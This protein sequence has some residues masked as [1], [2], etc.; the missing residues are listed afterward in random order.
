M[1]WPASHRRD[2]CRSFHMGR[3]RNEVNVRSGQYPFGKPSCGQ[4]R[5]RN[6][7]GRVSSCFDDDDFPRAGPD[8]LSC[9]DGTL[10]PLEGYH[11]WTTGFLVTGKLDGKKAA[12]AVVAGNEV[13]VGGCFR[14]C[15]VCSFECRTL[16][17]ASTPDRNVW[18]H[19]RLDWWRTTLTSWKLIVLD[20]P[21]LYP[22]LTI[23]VLAS[24]VTRRSADETQKI[25]FLSG[26]LFSRYRPEV[27]AA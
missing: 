21:F 18:Y 22:K 13:G 8:G 17:S 11:T 1:R 2:H 5:S 9:F 24:V 26:A 3:Y 14:G 4:V 6:H 19:Y 15:G 27:C 25:T 10:G 7:N 20:L 16:T 23:R 12:T